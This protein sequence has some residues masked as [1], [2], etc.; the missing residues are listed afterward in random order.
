MDPGY[1]ELQSAASQSLKLVAGGGG[2]V[3]G[4][5]QNVEV[6]LDTDDIWT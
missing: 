6:E 2:E 5:N 4:L 1:S 3:E